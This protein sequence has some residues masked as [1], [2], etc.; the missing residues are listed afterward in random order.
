MGD[1]QTVAR[2]E[3]GSNWKSFESLVGEPRIEVAAESLREHLG[4]LTGRSFL[5]V[6]CGSGLFSLA[7]CRLGAARVH[8][9]DFDP[10]SVE[11]AERLR[12]RWQVLDSDWTIEPGDILDNAYVESLGQ[13]D[14]V[15]S[16]GVLHHTGDMRGAWRTCAGWW[17][18]RP[19][20][21]LDLQRPGSREPHLEPTSSVAISGF[22][23]RSV[24]FT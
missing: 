12:L 17:P 19:A 15:Y 24:R 23:Q 10:E 2:F 11:A 14:V 16:W 6:G 5:D 8:S 1:S 20:V 13:W 7:A 4:E 21:H 9:F 3:F 22:R 18:R